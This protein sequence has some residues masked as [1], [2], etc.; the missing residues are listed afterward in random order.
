[1]PRPSLRSI[2]LPPLALL[3]IAACTGRR[4]ERAERFIGRRVAN[5]DTAP[6]RTLVHGGLRRRYVLRTPVGTSRGGPPLPFVMVLH[7]GGGNATN[8]EQLTGFTRLVEREHIIV[9]YPDGIE[10]RE[11]VPFET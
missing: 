5:A 11:G 1:M 2:L 3:A 8:A 10:S 6:R 4:Q 7:G 9:V